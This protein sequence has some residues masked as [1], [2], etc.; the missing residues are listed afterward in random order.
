MV[1]PGRLTHGKE[2]EGS[3][4]LYYVHCTK[5]VHLMYMYL[6]ACKYGHVTYTSLPVQSFTGLV[7]TSWKSAR[8]ME[9]LFWIQ[10][11]L[12]VKQQAL[13]GIK[14]HI[15]TVKDESFNR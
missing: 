11:F 3:N 2:R 7:Q 13:S 12:T 6:Y 5:F 10:H 9:C 4:T 1:W 15:M 14:P 8:C